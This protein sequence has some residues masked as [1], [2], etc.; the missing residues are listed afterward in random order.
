MLRERQNEARGRGG[1]QEEESSERN[2]R[3]RRENKL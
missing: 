1:G 2:W 3:E